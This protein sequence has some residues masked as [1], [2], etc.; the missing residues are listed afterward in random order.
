MDK[1]EI[2]AEL[3]RV[4]ELLPT[5]HLSQRQFS[6]NSRISVSTIKS[7]FGTWGRAVETAG[8]RGV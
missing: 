8:L 3:R 6:Q 4:A 2:I 1:Q 5:P 7:N